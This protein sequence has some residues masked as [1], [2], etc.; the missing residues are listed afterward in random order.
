MS[1]GVNETSDVVDAATDDE[2]EASEAVSRAT[3]PKTAP[4]LPTNRNVG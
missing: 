2:S 4:R 1:V 3:G